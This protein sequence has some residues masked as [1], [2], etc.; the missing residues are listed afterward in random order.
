MLNRRTAD[1]TRTHYRVKLIADEWTFDAD[2][3][4]HSAEGARL[5]LDS[6]V[7]IG[8]PVRL[9]VARDSFEG[10]VRYCVYEADRRRYTVGLR[11]AS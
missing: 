9:L 7:K 6:P 2:L 1:R 3:A 8:T 11:L 5:M 4:D 10:E